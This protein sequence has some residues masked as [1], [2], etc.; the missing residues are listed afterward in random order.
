MAFRRS[1]VRSR[2]GPP[3]FPSKRDGFSRRWIGQRLRGNTGLTATLARP[4]SFSIVFA[5]VINPP[6]AV[7]GSATVR[8]QAGQLIRRHQPPQFLE[9]VLDDG[10]PVA[11]RRVAELDHQE[12]PKPRGETRGDR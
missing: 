5:R 4:R 3:Y 12:T 8:G 11:F 6:L 7:L 9:P 10:D 1:P 2:S